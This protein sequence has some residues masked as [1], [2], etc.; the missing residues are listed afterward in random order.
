VAGPGDAKIHRGSYHIGIPDISRDQAT[1]MHAA[2]LLTHRALLTPEREALVELAS[3]RRYSFAALNARANRLAHFLRERLGVEKGDRV[4]ILAHNSIV[5]IDLFYAVGK[6]GA[7]LAPLNWRLAAR[8]L[9]YIIEDSRPKALLCGPEFT[10][11]LAELRAQVDVGACVAVEGTAIEGAL[12]YDAGLAEAPETEPTRSEPDAEDP[13]CILYTSGTT[14]QPKGAVIPHRQVLFNCLNTAAGWGL[15]ERDVSPVFVPLF[16]AG[17]L[18][19]FLTP[20]FYLGGKIILARGLEVEESLRV[21]EE[22]G[23]TVILGVPTIFQMWMKSP[24]FATA[25]FSRVRWFIS[26][27]A[28]CPEAI[29]DAWREQ[30]GV[31]FRQGYGLTEVGPN[32]FSMTDAE[33]VTKSG[34]VGKPIFHSEM[35]IVDEADKELPADTVGEL[36]IRGP[37]VCSGYWENPEA[38]AAAIRDG[39]FHTGDMARR[40][41]DGFYSIVGRF[42]DMIISGGENIY[43]AEVEAA[44]LE[45]LEVAEAALIGTPD[46][47]FGE[48]GLVVVVAR[49]SA[50]PTAESILRT[51]ADHLARYKVPKHLVFTDALP[52]SPYGKVQKAVLKQRYSNPEEGRG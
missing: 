14:G 51:C 11:T 27:G 47:K 18:F 45:H 48:V 23:C 36:L 33:S 2:D 7:V 21:I 15:S 50:A 26:G 44:V 29:M 22:E 46:A 3:G 34:S 41:G 39:W 52:Y 32:C 37:H 8:E 25:D 6:I 10:T 38:G 19:A 42:K 24:R 43:A 4:S 31:V 5:Y 12:D 49:E 16:H 9:A 20:L 35:R 30:K 1:L 13:Y 40:D 17:G 28:P